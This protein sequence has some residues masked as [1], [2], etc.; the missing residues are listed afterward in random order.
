MPF[1]RKNMTERTVRMGTYETVV[2]GHFTSLKRGQNKNLLTITP[3]Y[4]FRQ[5]GQ[6][7]TTPLSL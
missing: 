6:S 5:E 4:R 3:S 7:P 2:Q 1:W